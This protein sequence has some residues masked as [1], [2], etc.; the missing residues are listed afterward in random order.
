MVIESGMRIVLIYLTV[1][2]GVLLAFALITG[3]TLD[4][5]AH[6]RRA[7]DSESLFD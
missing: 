7:R 5:L 2:A 1:S 6:T 4:W 3:S